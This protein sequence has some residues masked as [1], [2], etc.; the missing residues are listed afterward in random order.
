[1]CS[2]LYSSADLLKSHCC[3][4]TLYALTHLFPVHHFATPFQGI[5]KDCIGNKWVNSISVINYQN[6]LSLCEILIGSY[7]GRRGTGL[8]KSLTK[9]ETSTYCVNDFSIF[10]VETFFK[11][12]WMFILLG[13]I[14]WCSCVYL[15][16][17]NIHQICLKN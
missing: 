16:I 6:N 13:F 1:M 9:I 15:S 10:Y 11:I 3:V 7:S 2:C 12:L 4:S 17:S 14:W 8:H 5:E